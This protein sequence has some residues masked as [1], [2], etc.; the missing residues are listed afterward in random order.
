M[1]LCKSLLHHEKWTRSTTGSLRHKETMCR[2]CHVPEVVPWF[3]L[4]TPDDVLVILRCAKGRC[5]K[6]YNQTK[7]QSLHWVCGQHPRHK[8]LQWEM[9]SWGRLC[10]S[11]QC[12][13]PRAEWPTCACDDIT[14]EA[15]HT[16]CWL[17]SLIFGGQTR[18]RDHLW[19]W[20]NSTSHAVAVAHQHLSKKI[21][22]KEVNQR[23][24]LSVGMKWWIPILIVTMMTEVDFLCTHLF[25]LPQCFQWHVFTHILLLLNV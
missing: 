17:R 22:V 13:R 23:P 18:L 14:E 15:T 10:S 8:E 25:V 11:E 3:G 6:H 19:M 20:G 24:C 16:V 21:L 9:D 1:Q 12:S 5:E 4:W 2:L 7:M